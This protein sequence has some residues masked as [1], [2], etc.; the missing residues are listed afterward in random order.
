MATM[1]DESKYPTRIA[2][3]GL[4]MPDDLKARIQ[5]AADENQRSMNAEIVSRLE[6]TFTEA[7][8]FK[9][10][11]PGDADARLKDL[12]DSYRKLRDLIGQLEKVVTST[13]P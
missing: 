12:E 2:P 8:R 9:D 7:W 10:I 5:A 1:A 6:Q 13:P 11:L 3:Y 4:R